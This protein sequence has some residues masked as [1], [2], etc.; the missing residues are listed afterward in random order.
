MNDRRLL[1]LAE[2]YSGD[3]HHGKTARGVMRYRPE[4]VVAIVR[5]CTRHKIPFVPRGA[6]TSLA[7]GTLAL[8]APDVRIHA[9][10]ARVE[11]QAVGRGLDVLHV[12]QLAHRGLEHR[13][14]LV[15]AQRDLDLA[16]LI[17]EKRRS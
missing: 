7:G 10:H 8:L 2:G 15:G 14:G 12:G 3:P 17:L 16:A 9:A 6:G 5:L 1:I 4:H 11:L 13:E